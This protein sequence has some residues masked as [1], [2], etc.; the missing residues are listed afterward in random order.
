MGD[1]A[2]SVVAPK[3]WNELPDAI[4][5]I[6]FPL[7]ILKKKLK[8]H[9]FIVEKKCND[10]LFLNRIVLYKYTMLCSV[11]RTNIEF[12]DLIT[13]YVNIFTW[14]CQEMLKYIK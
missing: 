11:K 4:R 14:F 2:S 5:N 10:C 13:L 7:D 9:Y 8:T 6:E 1:R 12:I 3:Y